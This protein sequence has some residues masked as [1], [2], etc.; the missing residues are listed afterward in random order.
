MRTLFALSLLLLASCTGEKDQDAPK[1]S[2]S[3]APDPAADLGP[4]CEK[5]CKK[6]TSCGI[7][8]A[9]KLAKGHA[10]ELQ[11]IEELRKDAPK[12]EETCTSACKASAVS[13][14]DAP[15]L[16]RAKACLDQTTCETF[17]R[18]LDAVDKPQGGS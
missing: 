10:H 2:A 13:G 11:L 16:A 7:E 1:A 14:D 5:V 17:D 15:L 6:S 4:Y 12:T 3:A 8:A 18:C 9:E